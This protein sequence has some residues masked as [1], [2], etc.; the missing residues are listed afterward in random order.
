MD[1]AGQGILDVRSKYP[2]ST[3]ADLYN[4]HTMPARLRQA[5]RANDR[6]VD[7]AYGYEGERS[8]AARVAFLFELYGK[9]AGVRPSDEP[10]I[11]DNTHIGRCQPH[12]GVA[13]N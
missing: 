10:H 11:Q 13:R 2:T 5:H 6:A 8:D 7:A 4:P 3:L 12:C 1:G 9:L